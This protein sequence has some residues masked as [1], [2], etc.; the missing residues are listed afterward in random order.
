M[1]RAF[2]AS[3]LDPGTWE[4]SVAS[5][6]S[7]PASISALFCGAVSLVPL[8]VVQPDN[9]VRLVATAAAATITILRFML[10]SFSLSLQ[11]FTRPPELTSPRMRYQM[12]HRRRR[13]LRD[14]P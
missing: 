7:A 3:S 6:A 10:S 5:V 9:R 1:P 8:L 14:D 13:C 4:Y 12:Q 2:A 11:S